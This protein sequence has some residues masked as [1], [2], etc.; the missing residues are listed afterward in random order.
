VACWLNPFVTPAVGKLASFVSVESIPNFLYFNLGLSGDSGL[1]FRFQANGADQPFVN[2]RPQNGYNDAWAH[3]TVTRVNTKL[4]FYL[5]GDVRDSATVVNNLVSGLSTPML[6]G[7]SVLISNFGLGGYFSGLL[8]E[9]R[10]YNRGL[11][12]LEIDSLAEVTRVATRPNLT[13]YSP[14][15]VFTLEQF[16]ADHPDAELYS[17]TGSRCTPRRASASL[18]LW[19]QGRTRRRVMLQ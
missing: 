15:Q 7:G 12:Q 10:F 19:V 11:S 1:G 8:D 5:N 14:V 2:Y 13:T 3:V 18:Y 16:M 4:K 6:V 9:L 17:I